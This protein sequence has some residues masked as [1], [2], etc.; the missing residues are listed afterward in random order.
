MDKETPQTVS[1]TEAGLFACAMLLMLG[2]W[3]FYAVYT[4]VSLEDAFIT[5]RYARNLA[6]GQGFVFNP[7]E[8]VLGTT[9]PLHALILAVF[10]RL[11]GST[12]IPDIS[13]LL[14]RT[15]HE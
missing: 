7:G 1:R 10:G 4:G 13:T 6:E 5:F 3:V 8:H 11:F 15:L 2:L 14:T 9:S 12:L